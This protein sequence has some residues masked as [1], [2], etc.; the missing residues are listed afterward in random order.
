MN[1]YGVFSVVLFIIATL[2]YLTSIFVSDKLFPD[3]VLIL[4]TIIVP[5]IGI[6]CALKDTNKARAFGVVANSLVLIFS[7]I[8]PALVTLFKT[9]F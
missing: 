4:L 9:L 6:L 7:G 3:P 5:F 2:V 8:I 1:K